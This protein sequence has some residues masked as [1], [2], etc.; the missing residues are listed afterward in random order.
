MGIIL[1]NVNIIDIMKGKTIKNSNVL[2]EG[3]KR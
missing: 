1:K 3:G 2:L